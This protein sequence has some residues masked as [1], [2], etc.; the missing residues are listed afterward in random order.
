MFTVQ[1]VVLHN[2][3]TWTLKQE[4]QRKLWVFEMAVL[5]RICGVTRRDRKRN[6]DIMNALDIDE[7]VVELLQKRRLTYFRHVSRMQLER[8]PHTLLHGHISGSRPQGR[9]RKKWI[10]NVKE[11]CNRLALTLTEAARAA[12]DWHQWRSIVRNLGCQR[13]RT[14]SSSPRQ[15]KS[16]QVMFTVI[17]LC[18]QIT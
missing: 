16:S 4:H 9:P 2:A 18:C 12:Q 13:A 3:E 8:Y 15:G 5:R 11:D 10:D 17:N 14:T 6:I 7:D 1:S